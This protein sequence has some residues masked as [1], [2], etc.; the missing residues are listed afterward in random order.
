MNYCLNQIHHVDVFKKKKPFFFFSSFISVDKIYP[1]L[2]AN[3]FI[4]AAEFHGSDK[5]ELPYGIKRAG[6]CSLDTC[7]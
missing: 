5:F 1:F 4:R 7:F 6:M 3:D 2:C